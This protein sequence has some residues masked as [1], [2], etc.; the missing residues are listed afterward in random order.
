M[1]ILRLKRE[2]KSK[3]RVF[4]LI[5][6]DNKISA[7]SGRQLEKIGYWDP[8]QNKLELKKELI[9]KYLDLGAKSTPVVHN[10]LIKAGVIN[11]AKKNIFKRKIKKQKAEEAVLETQPAPEQIKANND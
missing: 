6:A 9:L 1:L 10:L 8:H 11:S 2:G 7:T 3:K 4:R 5:I